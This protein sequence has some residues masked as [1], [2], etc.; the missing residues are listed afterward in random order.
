MD[1]P[2]NC[3][4]MISNERALSWFL[5]WR[6]TRVEVGNPGSRTRLIYVF[7]D[8]AIRPPASS[9]DVPDG[10]PAGLARA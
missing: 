9:G 7:E 2:R 3:H 1:D 6:P 4:H 8:L 5:P 10:V